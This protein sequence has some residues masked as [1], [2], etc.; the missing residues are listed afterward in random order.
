MWPARRLP[1]PGVSSHTGTRRP[2]SLKQAQRPHRP[3]IPQRRYA[4]ARTEKTFV[5]VFPNSNRRIH[6]LETFLSSTLAGSNFQR[7]AAF[8]ANSAKY[9]LGPGEASFT[10]ATFPDGSTR[11]LTPTLIL[12]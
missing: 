6:S 11:T 10:P 1:D 9:L 8:K 5:P 7:R 3:P 12:P 2:A 4:G